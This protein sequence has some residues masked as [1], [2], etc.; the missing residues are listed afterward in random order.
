MSFPYLDNKHELYT[1]KFSLIELLYIGVNQLMN[2]RK[3]LIN[4]LISIRNN[5]TLSLI[6]HYK[7]IFHIL[8]SINYILEVQ[9]RVTNDK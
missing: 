1:K 6:V 5:S 7:P 2:E 9:S 4:D 3:C 8:L